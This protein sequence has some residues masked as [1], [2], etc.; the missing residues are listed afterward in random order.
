MCAT[1]VSIEWSTF[2]SHYDDPFAEF[3]PSKVVW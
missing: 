1:T 2:Q 3:L